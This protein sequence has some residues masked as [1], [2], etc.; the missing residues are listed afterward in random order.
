MKSTTR[1]IAIYGG[2]ALAAC[3]VCCAPLVL[4]VLVGIFAAGGVAWAA[5]GAAGLLIVAGV[6]ASIAHYRHRSAPSGAEPIKRGQSC[7]CQADGASRAGAA[8]GGCAPTCEAAMP[9]SR[10]KGE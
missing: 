2:A 6:V 8:K 10:S 4:P 1:P 7:G 3:A 9:D 5:A